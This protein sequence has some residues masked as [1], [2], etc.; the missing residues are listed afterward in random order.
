[1]RSLHQ[2]MDL[3]EIAPAMVQASES[4]EQVEFWHDS[5][6]AMLFLRENGDVLVHSVL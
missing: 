6:T 4:F 1:M 2:G 5:R 3:L